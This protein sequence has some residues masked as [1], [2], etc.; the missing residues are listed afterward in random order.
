M[1]KN[2]GYASCYEGHVYYIW[3]LISETFYYVV[4]LCF[5]QTN[6]PINPA[7]ALY[8]VPKCVHLTMHVETRMTNNFCVKFI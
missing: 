6:G 1:Y 5:F 4:I 2:P 3:E 8:H 7:N